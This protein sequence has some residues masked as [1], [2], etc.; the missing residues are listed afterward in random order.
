MNKYIFELIIK[1]LLLSGVKNH[2]IS[3]LSITLCVINC[4]NNPQYFL[5]KDFDLHSEYNF[6][7]DDSIIR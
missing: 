5:K 2:D 4:K 3:L 1:D 6:F 7:K